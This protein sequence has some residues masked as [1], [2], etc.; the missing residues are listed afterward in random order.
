MIAAHPDDPLQDRT[1]LVAIGHIDEYDI[2][3]AY[4][5]RVDALDDQ[6]VALAVR[7]FHRL[8]HD[9]GPLVMREEVPD[10]SHRQEQPE[11]HQ[12]PGRD[13]QPAARSPLMH[14]HPPRNALDRAD[15]QRLSGLG[16]EARLTPKGAQLGGS[17]GL[18]GLGRRGKRS[19]WG[20]LTPAQRLLLECDACS[21]R[22]EAEGEGLWAH[23]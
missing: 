5:A 2:T 11:R 20:L 8:A 9:G 3:P 13:S 12:Y 22:R 1:A 17:G 21:I 19:R 18:C 23:N 16:T 4:L 10:A 14:E 7:G 15:Q 6:P